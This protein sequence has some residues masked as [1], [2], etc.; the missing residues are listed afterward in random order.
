MSDENGHVERDYTERALLG[1]LMTF[2]DCR[3]DDAA[4][5]ASADFRN[6]TYRLTHEAISEFHAEGQAVDLSTITE[7]VAKRGNIEWQIVFNAIVEAMAEHYTPALAPHYAA[8]IRR[9][10]AV[11]RAMA[12]LYGAIGKLKGPDSDPFEILA[13]LADGDGIVQPSRLTLLGSREF[14]DSD[15]KVEFLVDGLLVRS[16]PTIGGGPAKGCKTLTETAIVIHGATGTPVFGHERFTVP[17]PFRSAFFSMESGG[18]TVRTN[19]RSICHSLG[20]R[21]SDLD[22]MVWWQL[23][24]LKLSDP[25]TLTALRREIERKELDYIAVDPLYLALELDGDD[26]KSI[27][28]M[29]ARLREV[30]KVIDDTGCTIKLLHHGIKRPQ[31]PNRPMKLVDLSGAGV[32]EWAGQW[33]L[34]SRR[35]EYDEERPGHHEIWARYGGRDFPGSL[36]ALDIEEFSEWGE[37]REWRVVVRPAGEVAAEM[38]E[39]DEARKHARKDAE[40]EARERS[41]IEKHVPEVVDY[42]RKHPGGSCEEPTRKALGITP[43]TWRVIYSHLY[44]NQQIVEAVVP[45]GNGQTYPGFKLA[46]D[47]HCHALPSTATNGRVVVSG[48]ASTHTHTSTPEGGDGSGGV[49]VRSKGAKRKPLPRSQEGDA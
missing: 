47:D 19:A 40:R 30:G 10:A 36:I 1:C 16:K 13:A 38:I 31:E 35:E 3:N 26:D 5:V 39:D 7:A 14:D 45:R 6:L 48:A 21:L 46:D 25:T 8:K 29:G 42:L 37:Q 43:A 23:D 18:A 17:K 20:C 4:A 34:L 11:D 49:R 9:A 2:E 41:L 24:S 33:G 15:F 32:Q 22:G 44:R 27:Y 12:K 28:K